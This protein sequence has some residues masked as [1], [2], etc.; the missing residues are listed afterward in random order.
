MS[1]KQQNVIVRTRSAGVFAGVL[2]G[3]KSSSVTVLN[4]RRLWYWSGA[5]SLSEL[6]NK[7]V[8]NP[9]QC[10]FPAAVAEVFLTEVIE[11]LPM[12]TEAV[13]SISK[14][15]EWSAR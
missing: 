8:A 3:K 10:K 11:I 7:G 12:S 14:V 4:A 1:A 5:A 15:K 13:D 6:A 9:D 2:K